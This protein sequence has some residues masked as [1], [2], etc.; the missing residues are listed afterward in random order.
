MKN[1]KSWFSILFVFCWMTIF[2]LGISNA[3]TN[4]VDP[5]N[6]AITNWTQAI[7]DNPEDSIAYLKR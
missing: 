7:A 4:A 1:K 3:Q 6:R 5:D 2:P